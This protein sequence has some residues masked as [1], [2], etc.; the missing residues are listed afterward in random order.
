MVS[1]LIL[2]TLSIKVC[3]PQERGLTT[4]QYRQYWG[5]YDFPIDFPSG[6]NYTIGVSDPAKD[7]VCP[8]VRSQLSRADER[9]TFITADMAGLMI[10]QDSKPRTQTSGN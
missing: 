7:W 8:L 4:D 3:P 1:P 2:I 10:D 5:A 6:V 9:T